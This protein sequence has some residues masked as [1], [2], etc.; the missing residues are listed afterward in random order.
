MSDGREARR[1]V[2]T[3]GM[4]ADLVNAFAE[5]AQATTP[6]GDLTFQQAVCHGL[7]RAIVCRAYA[8]PIYQLCHLV[9][10]ADACGRGNERFEWL[11]F[12]GSRLNARHFRTTL[13]DAAGS[14]GWRR[15]GFEL[16]G[17]GVAIRYSDGVFNVAYTRMPL[18]AAMFEF[19]VSAVPYSVVD[20]IFADMF[21][22]AS[23]QAA[24]GGAANALQ[25]HLYGFLSAH[26]SSAQEQDKFSALIE[27]LDGRGD[28]ASIEIDDQAVLDFWRHASAP[29]DGAA[30]DFRTYR[31][32]FE[33]FIDLMRSL[34]RAE[35]RLAVDNAQPIGLDAETGEIDVEALEPLVA[36]SGEWRSPLEILDQ[37]PASRIKLLN[38]TELGYVALLSDCGP[39]S[40]RLP[41]SLLRC[42]CL[43]AAQARITQGLRRKLARGRLA[44][45]IDCDGAESYDDRRRG[46]GALRAHIA[47]VL[48]AA[49]YVT[50]RDRA[51]AAGANVVALGR[52]EPGELM[53]D[54]MEDDMVVS[55]QEFGAALDE[56]RRA[57]A[58]ISRHGFEDEGLDDD[59]IVE[60]FA[61]GAGALMAVDELI[62]SFVDR[63]DGLDRLAGLAGRFAADKDVFRDQFARLYG[64]PA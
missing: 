21:G 33:G 20:D 60:G 26:L 47:R 16:S 25:R 40:A 62:A 8:G 46:Y 29:T 63:L 43:G 55:E 64:D 24:I 51:V 44:D 5:V 13:T 27:F 42:E 57:F 10:V 34:E 4:S 56:A 48:K 9:N 54:A 2:L 38:R 17:N 61:L 39:M 23:R 31:T 50:M 59:E 30:S 52:S 15:P 1:R 6:D 58:R 49:A 11:F 7:A 3:A 45:L 18:L 37:E 28:G 35:T 53:D 14:R 12:A 22:D 41:I 36:A 19:L 32:V